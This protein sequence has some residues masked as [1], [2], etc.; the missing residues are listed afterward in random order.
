MFHSLIS[1]T[2]WHFSFIWLSY[3]VLIA[4]IS[5][6]FFI[7]DAWAFTILSFIVIFEI[8]LTVNTKIVQHWLVFCSIWPG[9]K[10]QP[11]QLESAICKSKCSLTPFFCLPLSPFLYLSLSPFLPF[12]NIFLLS[13]LT[14]S[15]STFLFHHF[16]PLHSQY[17]SPFLS[18]YFSLFLPL[19]FYF[20]PF[21]FPSISLSSSSTFHFSFLVSLCFKEVSYL[22]Y[23]LLGFTE[24]SRAV[25]NCEQKPFDWSHL[26]E[27]GCYANAWKQELKVVE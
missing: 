23:L 19:S 13:F 6:S 20:S 24:N 3:I 4:Q 11:P 15:L 16:S 1:P 9:K 7:W 27:L 21:L 8:I 14:I 5:F 2:V 10:D 18:Y 22:M 26:E 12:L 17:F 25:I